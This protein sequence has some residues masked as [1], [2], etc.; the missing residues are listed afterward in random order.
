MFR[1][2]DGTQRSN[3]A[4]TFYFYRALVVFQSKQIVLCDSCICNVYR[5]SGWVKYTKYTEY[6][7]AKS[8]EMFFHAWVGPTMWWSD[9]NA[10][11]T[12]PFEMCFQ[13]YLCIVFRMF[14]TQNSAEQAGIRGDSRSFDFCIMNA[15]PYTF[16]F[17]TE[18][19]R[20]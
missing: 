1:L 2:L 17:T 19:A 4:L 16:T 6:R 5:C 13:V 15:Y 12:K 3:Q 18:N 9:I 14:W 11:N 7:H 10:F 20:G 8:T